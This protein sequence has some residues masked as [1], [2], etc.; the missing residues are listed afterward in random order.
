MKEELKLKNNKAS[1][2]SGPL[3]FVSASANGEEQEGKDIM[4][5]GA[6]NSDE[7][8]DPVEEQEEEAVDEEG[9]LYNRT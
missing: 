2:C 6:D 1:E 5:R 4:N 7:A 8:E 3:D 9:V